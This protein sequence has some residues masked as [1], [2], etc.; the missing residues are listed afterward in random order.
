MIVLFTDFGT[1]D[2]YVG[3]VKA[4]LHALAPSQIVIDLLHEA[5]SYNAH[6]G[7]HL[8]AAFARRFRPA[9]Y[10]WRWSIPASARRA[11]PSS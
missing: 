9:A 4:R 1:H 7:A 6:A 11:T 5:P 2:P 8:L 10:F 3:Q